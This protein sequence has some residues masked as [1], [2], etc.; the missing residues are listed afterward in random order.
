MDEM[1]LLKMSLEDPAGFNPAEA[2]SRNDLLP[3]GYSFRMY[4]PGMAEEWVRIQDSAD[5]YIAV[6]RALFEEE[7]GR[8]R[9]ELPRRMLFLAHG[10]TLIGSAT[11]WLDNIYGEKGTGRL[12]WVAIAPEYQG[13]GLS[14]P[15]VKKALSIFT[16]LGCSRAYLLTNAVRFIA[17][18]LY[19]KIGFTPVFR[20]PEEQESWE[21]ILGIIE[22]LRM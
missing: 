1:M 21:E 5:D 3:A 10:D 4:S 2:S 18:S 20:S 16:A 15:L 8:H 6:D 17:I 22:S 14:I 11:A 9:D 19:L 7:F 13:R 12:H